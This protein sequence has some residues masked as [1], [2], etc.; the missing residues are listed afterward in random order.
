M[1]DG[2]LIQ[3]DGSTG[4]KQAI[5]PGDKSVLLSEERMKESEKQFNV[6]F[7][8]MTREQASEIQSYV[9]KNPGSEMA[10][11]GLKE[12]ALHAVMV[13][14]DNEQQEAKRKDIEEKEQEQESPPEPESELL[15][16]KRLKENEEHFKIDFSSMTKEEAMEIQSECEKNPEGDKAK[17][18]LK[19]QVIH[20]IKQREEIKQ[21]KSDTEQDHQSD[22]LSQSRTRENGKVAEKEPTQESNGQTPKEV[23][24]DGQMPTVKA[25][26]DVDS[27]N[28]YPEISYTANGQNGTAKTPKRKPPS[29]FFEWIGRIV[30]SLYF[31]LCTVSREKTEA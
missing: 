20:V 22:V 12:Q 23:F 8:T 27:H 4:Q 15:S 11:A 31:S 24:A 26:I 5:R 28:N 13:R 14:E 1:K 16:E 3:E 29:G 10:K 18:G 17:A 25:R 6:N 2:Q 7:D 9:D 21:V 19:E 30:N